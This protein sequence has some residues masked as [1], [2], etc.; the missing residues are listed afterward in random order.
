MLPLLNMQ[1]VFRWALTKEVLR[2]RAII[3]CAAK[4][5]PG[6]D[7]DAGDHRELT[8]VLAELADALR[9]SVVRSEPAAS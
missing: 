8:E 7:L 9:P 3:D 1:A 2:R 6:P 5:A 4:R